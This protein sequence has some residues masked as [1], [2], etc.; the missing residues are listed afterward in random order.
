MLERKL[1]DV[2]ATD[3]PLHRWPPGGN[4]PTLRS[5]ATSAGRRHEQFFACLQDKNVLCSWLKVVIRESSM[6]TV[7]KIFVRALSFSV[8]C[9]LI[10]GAYFWRNRAMQKA[11]ADKEPTNSETSR[12][13]REPPLLCMFTTFKPKNEK[14]PVNT[15]LITYLQWFDFLIIT[16]HIYYLLTCMCVVRCVSYETKVSDGGI[17]ACILCQLI[18]S[19]LDGVV[20]NQTSTHNHEHLFKHLWAL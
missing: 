20:R 14:L 12:L 1:E 11:A 15:Y 19:L 2:V 3:W 7:Q 6:T 5:G 9:L 16:C 18:I 17:D 10:L 4:V 13:H 8:M